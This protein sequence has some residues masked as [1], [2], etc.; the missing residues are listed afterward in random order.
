MCNKQYKYQR[1]RMIIPYYAYPE[2]SKIQH[3]LAARHVNPSLPIR[4]ILNPDSG[5]GKSSN[6]IYVVAVKTLREASITV[7]GYINTNYSLRPIEEIIVEINTW[8]DWYRPDGIFLDAMGGSVEYYQ[9]LT[10]YIKSIG[11]CFSIGNPGMDVPINYADA[12]D[13]VIVANISKEPILKD[14]SKWDNQLI[15]NTKIGMIVY[16]ASPYPKEFI[17]EAKRFVGWLYV[18]EQGVS[19]DPW[20]SLSSYL[21]RLTYALKPSPVGTIVPFYIFPTNEAIQ[22][23]LDAKK[24]FPNVPIRVILNPESGP[25]EIN[26][27]IYI[28]AAAKLK[29]V[30]ISVLGY[31][32]T[33]YAARKEEEVKSEI[34]KWMNWYQP[35][36]IFLDE[37]GLDHSYYSSM[38]KFAKTHGIKYVVGN[39]GTHIDVSASEDVDNVVIFEDGHLP[40]FAQ[41]NDWFALDNY[42]TKITMLNYNIPNLPKEY[43]NEAAKHFGWIYMTQDGADENPWDNFSLYFLPFVEQLNEL[44]AENR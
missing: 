8:K 2:I 35:D 34:Q 21:G 13:T 31:V 26:D 7:A 15:P 22:P 5:V 27:P 37:M 18:T 1:G 38:T 23:L 12:V 42:Q 4:I 3:I 29:R 10:A 28:N 25:G 16:G 44:G 6:A 17:K 39:P 11:L 33:K 9:K 41:F 20:D 36:G 40:N 30:G 24:R 43:I 14:Y 32:S 19:S